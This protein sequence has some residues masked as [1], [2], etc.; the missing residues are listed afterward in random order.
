[1]LAVLGLQTSCASAADM[2]F[3]SWI[4]VGVLMKNPEQGVPGMLLLDSPALNE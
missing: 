2:A 4:A 1:M 3:S